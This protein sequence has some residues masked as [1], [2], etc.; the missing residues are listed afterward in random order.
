MRA[1]EFVKDF[2][3]IDVSLEIQKDDA[4]VDDDDADNQVV[5]VKATSN[6]REL[7]H[8]LFTMSYDGQGLILNPQDLEVDERYRGQGIAQTMY[9]FVKSK[10]YRIRRSGQ[11]TDAGAA[12]W[13][14]HRPGENVWEDE[15]T[16]F[17]P[18]PDRDHNDDVPDPVFVLAN[19]WWNA[20]EKQP[21]IESVLNSMGWSIQQVESEDDAVQLQHRDGTSYFISADDFDPDVFENF[22][23]GKKPGRKGL[24]K[25]VGIPKKATLAQLQK[26]ASSSTGERRRMAQWQLN[27]RRGKAK[28]AK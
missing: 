17:A 13:Q 19:R 23:D 11:Q 18:S 27:M 12:F 15:L 28:K 3:G 21:Q 20:A 1:Q 24:S 7:G 16:E 6:G 22:A 2:E 8:V 26:I 4:Y 9:D 10:G 14:R 5:F 25:R